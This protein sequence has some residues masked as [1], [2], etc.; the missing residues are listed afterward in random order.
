MHDALAGTQ[1][2][3]EYDRRAGERL[4]LKGEQLAAVNASTPLVAVSAGAGSGKT[5]VLVERF[6]NFVTAD[7]VSPLNI[8]AITYTERAAAEMKERIIRRFEERGDESNRRRA[9]AAYISTIHGFCARILRENPLTAGIDPA[10][11]IIDEMRLGF[12]LDEERERMHGDSWYLQVRQLF[13]P[14]GQER[15]D[16]L[17]DLIRDCVF[18]AREFGKGESRE[19]CWSVDQLVAAAMQRLDKYMVKT[20]H[21]ARSDLLA[22]V[23]TIASATIGGGKSAESRQILCELIARLPS[24]DRFDSEWSSE[25]LKHTG[26]TRAVKDIPLREEIKQTLT[27][28]RESIKQLTDIDRSSIE[29]TERDEIA[30]LKEGIYRHAQILRDRYEGMKAEHS[31]LDF[32]DLQRLALRLLEDSS[33]GTEYSSRFRHI[34]LDEAQDTNQV[35]K[36]IVDA[37]LR[38]EDQC[39]FA[40]GDAK[41]SVY[42]FR[43]AD[44]TLF[45]EMYRTSG[46]GRRQLQDNYRSRAEIID[47][48]NAVGALLWQQGDSIEYLPLFCKFAYDEGMTARPRV[49]MM[50]IQKQEADPDAGREKA[51]DAAILHER[52]A[53]AIAMQIRQIIEGDDTTAPLVVYDKHEKARRNARYGD[54]AILVKARTHFATYERV[55]GDLGIPVVADGGRG[56]FS[57][58][59]VQDILAA[60]RVVANPYDEIALLT[61]LRSPL[62]GWSDDDLVALRIVARR[63]IWKACANGFTPHS[64][65]ADPTAYQTIEALRRL[66][67]ALPPVRLIQLLLDRTGYN[68][69]LLRMKRG[70]TGIANILKLQEFARE[71][72]DVDGPDLHSFLRRAELAEDYL[73]K[74]HEASIVAEGDDVVLLG[75]IHG[76]K[77]LEWPVVILAGLDSAFDG[78]DTGSFYCAAD[79]ML[80]IQP[81][82]DD[83]KSRKL[84]TQQLV[85]DAQK[86]RDEEEGRRLL[87]VGMTR[88]RECLILSGG[89]TPPDISE[90]VSRRLGA[91]LKWLCAAAGAN[92]ENCESGDLMIGGASLHVSMVTE[93]TVAPIR[94]SIAMDDENLVAARRSVERGEPVSWQP[95]DSD[96]SARIIATVR[97]LSAADA[98]PVAPQAARAITTVTQLVYFARCP[99]VYYFNLVLQIDEHP[100]K[101]R[102]SEVVTD[103]RYSA[104]ELGT[105]VHQ[106]LE[107]ADFSAPPVDEARRLVNDGYSGTIS[108]TDRDRV[109]R[110]LASVLSDPL[111]DRARNAIRLEREYPFDLAIDGRL[112]HG[113][114]DLVFTDANGRGVVVDYKSNDLAAPD[115]VNVLSRYY[116]P[117]IEMYA[118]AASKAELVQ[119]AEATL[120]FLNKSVARTF[121]VNESRLDV[122][123]QQMAGALGRIS[124]GDWNSEPGEKCR[125]CGYR[126]RGFCD[127]GKRFV[128]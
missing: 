47:F 118:L 78:S 86:R 120:Y 44:V 43:G 116:E 101:R 51:D 70:R 104:A 48:V 117:Q 105:L 122:V 128:E 115:R 56:F 34:L 84:V 79:Q 31:L 18:Q 69:A 40:V 17:F 16:T 59:E 10:F 41:Q 57:G 8:L 53:L 26:F 91:P 87:Y 65:G 39:L 42:G 96:R 37:L 71:S 94:G 20:W 67:H 29:N 77:G 27:P 119:P 76:S 68:A 95:P 30:P 12:F 4:A 58:R 103:R 97:E 88:A 121:E 9:E 61:A 106:M 49:E 123:E 5:T 66:S 7:G 81:K 32:D 112:V 125:N 90:A 99:M 108:Q 100:R 6:L 2:A 92:T 35:Q 113:V 114:I 127:V 25:F 54:I 82:G 60:L 52:E 15:R 14:R 21:G 13:A 3:T 46:D 50:L 24:M 85:I 109:E 102:S 111:I 55:L 80:V 36:S 19:E 33:V 98:V 93:A 1:R 126:T 110:M 107:R 73:A 124:D 28:A 45:G 74:E 89:Y 38:R 75:T 63:D 62:F 83:G 11:G 64:E 22:I 72:A 23:E